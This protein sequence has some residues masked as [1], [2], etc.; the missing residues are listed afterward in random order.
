MS[1]QTLRRRVSRAA[2][3]LGL[4]IT[5]AAV[6]AACAVG[7]V[8]AQDRAMSQCTATPPGFPKRLSSGT[9]AVDWGL[10]GY[11]CVYRLDDGEVVRRPPP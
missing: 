2:A 10:G 9:V 6:A 3:V 8:A 5:T 11:T 1:R 4:T 7:T